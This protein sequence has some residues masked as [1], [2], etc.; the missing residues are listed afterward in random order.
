M[1][2]FS[3]KVLYLRRYKKLIFIQNIEW[4]KHCGLVVYKIFLYENA[5]TLFASNI[6][7]LTKF[8]I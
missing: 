8:A 5:S 7:N 6:S 3:D 4:H 1:I 2:E